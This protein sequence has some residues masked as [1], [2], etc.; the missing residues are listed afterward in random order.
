MPFTFIPSHPR[1]MAQFLDHAPVELFRGRFTQADVTA[2]TA[3]MD[4]HWSVWEDRP[5]LRHHRERKAQTG[6][7]LT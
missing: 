7:V 5:D 2:L 6:M 3:Q 4:D 1:L